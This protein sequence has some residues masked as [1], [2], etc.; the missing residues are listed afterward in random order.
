MHTYKGAK[1]QGTEVWA[2]GVS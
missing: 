1:Q 2:S